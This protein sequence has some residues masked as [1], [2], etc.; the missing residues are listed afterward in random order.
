MNEN[1]DYV[2][3]EVENETDM[4]NGTGGVHQLRQG[5]QRRILITVETSSNAGQL[6]IVCDEIDQVSLGAICVRS[7]TKQKQLDSYQEVD[8]AVLRERCAMLL[9]SFSIFIKLYIVVRWGDALKR[10]RDYL[11]RHLQELAQKK[12]K[13][14]EEQMREKSLVNQWLTLTEERNAVLVPAP[15][16]GV[17]GAPSCSE[18]KPEIGMEE[19]VPVMFL[20]ISEDILSADSSPNSP[21]F[22]T[23]HTAGLNSLLPKEHEAHFVALPMIR[24]SYGDLYSAWSDQR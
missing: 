23:G 21:R 19:H 11:D 7:T 16:S 13:S 15:D 14:A 4:L 3:V 24:K 17:P 5:L 9:I 12:D 8:L 6:P 18:F 10:R 2:A 22:V 1:G 20:D